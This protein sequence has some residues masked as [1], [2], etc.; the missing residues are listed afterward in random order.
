MGEIREL[1]LRLDD[2]GGGAE[3]AIN[4]APSDRRQPWLV[5]ATLVVCEDL[6]RRPGLGFRQIP[7]D[8]ERLPALLGRPGVGG[9]NGP[10][11]P[12]RSRSHL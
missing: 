10:L 8:F 6:G 12:A 3:C 1:E 7:V 9:Q 4:V 11:A 2:L 5:R